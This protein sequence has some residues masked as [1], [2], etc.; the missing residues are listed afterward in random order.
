MTNIAHYVILLL[1]GLLF[2]VP[3]DLMSQEVAATPFLSDING[4]GEIQIYAFGDSIT[5]GIGDGTAIGE[6]VDEADFII[7]DAG[8]P[9]R[10]RA[11]LGL[12]V[13]N[14]GVPGERLVDNGAL[15]FARTLK[16]SSSDVVIVLEGVNDAIS[17]ASVSL[18]D[19]S[20]QK[21]INVARVLGKRIIVGTLP[22]P[23]CD[24]SSWAPFTAQYS[25]R[26]RQTALVNQVGLLD[27]ERVWA[28][29]CQNPR[30]CELY[31]I[32]EGL[33][34]NTRGY[35]VIA[36]AV[37]ATLLNIDIFSPRGPELLAGA[38]G[39]DSSQILVK[40]DETFS[41]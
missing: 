27:L 33:H 16:S 30:E 4:D 11:L 1:L 13:V 40:S 18:Y 8:Y 28:T 39:V 35:D 34:P 2:W 21:V 22:P 25:A 6:F 15:R 19:R 31:N 36:Q 5:S 20:I 14:G 3:T 7:R 32:P 29:S 38:L 24:R 23:C 10:L 41:R 17:T 12:P 26:V 37:A 9:A